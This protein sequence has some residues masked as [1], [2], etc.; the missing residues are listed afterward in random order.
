[1]SYKLLSVFIIGS[2]LVGMESCAT[3]KN[4]Q[5]SIPTSKTNLRQDMIDTA[6]GFLGSKYQYGGKGDKGFDCSGLVCRVFYENKIDIRGNSSSL[7]NQGKSITLSKAQVGDFIFFK[8]GNRINHV[9]LIVEKSGDALWVI[10]STSSRGV[11]RENI[12]ASDYWSSKEYFI[13][14]LISDVNH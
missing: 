10:H 1:M 13:K 5:S 4:S 8:K 7:A 11:I 9:A 12:F 6:K 14:D 2:I 3:V